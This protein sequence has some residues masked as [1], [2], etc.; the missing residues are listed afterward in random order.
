MWSVQGRGE[1]LDLNYEMNQSSN[2][3]ISPPPKTHLVMGWRGWGRDCGIVCMGGNMEYSLLY[4]L[5]QKLLISG[6]PLQAILPDPFPLSLF[7]RRNRQRLVI[8]NTL[9]NNQCI[10]TTTLG[11][12]DHNTSRLKLTRRTRVYEKCHWCVF[13]L[14]DWSFITQ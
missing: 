2:V 6:R 14:F 13:S 3:F 4:N 9:G 8:I 11:C 1:D 12:W 7:S 5:W 10:C